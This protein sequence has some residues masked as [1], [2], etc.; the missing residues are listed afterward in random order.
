MKNALVARLREPSTYAGL[1]V[2][3]GSLSF[4]PNSANIAETITVVGTALA[5]LLAI[6][7]PENKA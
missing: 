6:W 5:G 2:F 7:L 1:A 3:V 4:L